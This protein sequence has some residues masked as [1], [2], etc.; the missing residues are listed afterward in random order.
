MAWFTGAVWT[1]QRV[2]LFDR[3][4]LMHAADFPAP[5]PPPKS[6]G[7]GDAGYGHGSQS[8]LLGFH[9]FAV[10]GARLGFT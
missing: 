6:C 2:I 5:F 1:K 10:K 3:L 9:N 4:C 7:F 8:P